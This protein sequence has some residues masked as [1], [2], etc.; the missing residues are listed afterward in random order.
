MAY[1]RTTGKRLPQCDSFFVEGSEQEEDEGLFEARRQARQR[2]QQI[3]AETQYAMAEEMSRM[4]CEEYQEDILDHMEHM[5]VSY[6]VFIQRHKP[7]YSYVY[8]LILTLNRARRFLML[9]VLISRQ[10]SS[11]LCDHIS[12]ISW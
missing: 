3:N 1:Q 12:S 6:P 11:G 2:M 8:V 4:V 10:K 9:P 7:L 5:E